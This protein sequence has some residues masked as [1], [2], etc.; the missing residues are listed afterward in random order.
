MQYMTT[1][2][3]EATWESHI[4]SMHMHLSCSKVYGLGIDLVNLCLMTFCWF[5]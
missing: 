2:A 4:H 3:K 5:F 1:A